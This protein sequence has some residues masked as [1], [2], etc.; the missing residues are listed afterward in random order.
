MFKVKKVLNKD[1]YYSDLL[2]Y[3]PHFFTSRELIVKDN[4]NPLSKYLNIKPENLKHPAQVHSANI[5]IAKENINTYDQTDALILDDKKL[6]IYLSFADCTPV[7]LYDSKNNTG[8]I[9]HAGWRGTA[10]KIALKTFLK[11]EELYN[12]KPENITALIGPCISF[13][14]FETSTEAI[15]ELKKTVNDKSGLFRENYADLKGINK[16]QLQEAGIDK[17]DVCPYCTVLDN[18]KFFSYRKENKTQK[19]HSAVLKLP[20]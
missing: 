19:R 5:D 4:I 10:Q 3:V 7:I 9:A 12:S 11:M 6:A 14:C 18:D 20:D 15:S 1:V 8:A 16:R 17:I 2:E 13:S